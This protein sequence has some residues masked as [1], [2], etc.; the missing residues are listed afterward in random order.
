MELDFSQMLAGTD[1][2]ALAGEGAEATEGATPEIAETLSTLDPKDILQY[3]ID[4]GKL[5]PETTL[6]DEASAELPPEGE[7]PPAE[8]AL[9][10][11]GGDLSFEGMV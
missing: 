8:G 2:G 4:Q 11:A 1:K 5:A 7:V 9:P 3:L 10:P 6:I